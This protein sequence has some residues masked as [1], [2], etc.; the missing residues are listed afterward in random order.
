YAPSVDQS[1]RAS[2]A[3]TARIVMA[4]SRSSSRCNEM[5]ASRSAKAV[6][7]SSARWS[8]T[9]ASSVVTSVHTGTGSPRLSHTCLTHG[10]VDLLSLRE[11]TF[12]VKQSP[13]NLGGF[14][15]RIADLLELAFAQE[16]AHGD[17]AG[18]GGADDLDDHDD[19]GN[20]LDLEDGSGTREGIAEHDPVREQV[21]GA[22]AESHGQAEGGGH[23]R[24]QTVAVEHEH[25]G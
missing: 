5:I 23:H 12:A 21:H 17:D 20:G 1:R 6:G 18:E 25:H 24:R 2:K 4:L 7:S 9:S 13:R 11:H 19:V 10:E 15:S 16:D 8:R 22:D 14:L 3:A